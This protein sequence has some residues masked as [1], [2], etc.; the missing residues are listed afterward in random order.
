MF[1]LTVTHLRFACEAFTALQLPGYSAGSQPR[2][3]LGNVMRCAYGLCHS[4]GGCKPASVQIWRAEM[5]Q[6]LFR[7]SASQVARPIAV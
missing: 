1:P 5:S 7:R 2:G 3:A 4:N 6:S